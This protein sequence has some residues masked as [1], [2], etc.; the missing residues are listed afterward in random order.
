MKYYMAVKRTS[1]KHRKKEKKKRR[2]KPS[3]SVI[4]LTQTFTDM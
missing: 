4:M 3:C 1:G 2:T